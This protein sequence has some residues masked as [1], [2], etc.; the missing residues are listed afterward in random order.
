MLAKELG[1]E[2]KSTRDGAQKLI[3]AM[4]ELRQKVGLPGS[5]KE[6]GIDEGVFMSQLDRLI[7][8]TLA[9]GLSSQK[10]T[11]EEVKEIYLKA[12]EGAEPALPP[13]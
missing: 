6:I 2:M 10:P 13:E 11:P 7:E 8:Y 3:K 12:W 4:V 9:S 5:I 1:M